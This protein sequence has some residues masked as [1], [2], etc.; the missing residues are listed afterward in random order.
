MQSRYYFYSDG[1]E[2]QAW[3]LIG[4]AARQCLELGLHHVKPYSSITTGDRASVLRLFWTTFALDRR[5]SFGAGLPF[6]IQEVDID[7]LLPEPV[8][9]VCQARTAQALLMDVG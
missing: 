6:T 7:P 3:R 5:W 1:D 8:C 4:V 9:Y 2:T